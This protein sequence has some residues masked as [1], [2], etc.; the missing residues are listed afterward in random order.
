MGLNPKPQTP[1]LQAALAAA[2]AAPVRHRLAAFNRGT[3]FGYPG[4]KLMR[5]HGQL[6]MMGCTQQTASRPGVG[7]PWS[8]WNCWARIGPES[9]MCRCP[10]SPRVTPPHHRQAGNI[11]V[12]L[13]RVHGRRRG[14]S[15]DSDEARGLTPM[16]SLEPLG[17]DGEADAGAWAQTECTQQ[18][19]TRPGGGPPWSA[20]QPG[21][22]GTGPL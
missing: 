19:A 8:A 14:V 16:I 4:V 22:C 18:T 11:G 13:M 5:V 9:R 12:K 6:Q 2:H 10:G 17:Q 1:N 7:P 15:A 20:A 3:P 21:A